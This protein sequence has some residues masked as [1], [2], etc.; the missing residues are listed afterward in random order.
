MCPINGDNFKQDEK[1]KD[2]TEFTYL[3]HDNAL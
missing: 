3:F 2:I 1:F